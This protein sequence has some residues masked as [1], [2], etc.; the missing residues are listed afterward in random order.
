VANDP[1]PIQ[2]RT[3][4]L[5]DKPEAVNVSGSVN[6]PDAAA[7]VPFL[8]NGRV[9]HVA[10]REGDSVRRGQVLAVLESTDY[11]LAVNGAA[12]QVAA[13]KVSLNRAEDEYRRMKMLFDSKSL[14]PNDFRK[15]EAVYQSAK[16]QLNQAVAGEKSARK[17]LTDATLLAPVNGFIS[18]RSVEPG[19]MA[20]AGQSAFQIVTLDPVEVQVGVPESNIHLVRVGQHAEVQIPALP[21]EAFSGTVRAINVATDNST[22]TYSTCIRVPNP[23]HRLRIGMV[24][25]VQIQ[26]DRQIKVLTLPGSAIVRDPQGASLVFVYYPEQKRVY[27]RRLEI[28]NVTEQEVVIQSGLKPEEQVVIG[29]QQSLRDGT[30]VQPVPVQSPHLAVSGSESK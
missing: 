12:A 6:S 28:S 29:G 5:V 20:A 11:S 24:A 15:F 16:E 18:K 3:P 30:L 10:V 14:P 7:E 25:E 17:H 22:R 27:S 26:G 8:V 23:Q 2:T 13:A 9:T 21:G 19:N 1:A 4:L